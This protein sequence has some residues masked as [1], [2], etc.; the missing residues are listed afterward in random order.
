MNTRFLL[1]V[2]SIVTTITFAQEGIPTDYLT[3]EFHKGRR[4]AL[5]AKLPANSAAVFF[6]NPMVL[7]IMR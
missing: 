6:A 1:F 3:P 2:F 4:D 7:P 5:R